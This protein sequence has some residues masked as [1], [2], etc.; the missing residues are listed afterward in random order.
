MMGPSG[1]EAKRSAFWEEI[2]V[3]EY[4]EIKYLCPKTV[5]LPLEVLVAKSTQNWY[6]EPLKVGFL[7]LLLQLQQ[8]I[9]QQPSSFPT[10]SW[11]AYRGKYGGKW[12][13]MPVSCSWVEITRSNVMGC[14]R[15][16]EFA[17][18]PNARI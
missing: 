17:I 3:Y 6:Q 9:F 13:H 18:C 16:L 11:S 15:I 4:K 8:E 1:E 12:G 2:P 7:I 14:S 10:G 5:Q